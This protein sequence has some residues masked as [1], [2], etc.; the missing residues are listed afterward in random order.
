[1][2]HGGGRLLAVFDTGAAHDRGAG[3]TPRG[4]E[5]RAGQPGNFHSHTRGYF[6]RVDRQEA[7]RLKHT[8]TLTLSRMRLAMRN[9]AFLFFSLIMPIAFLFIYAGIFG[10]GIRQVV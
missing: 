8:W 9:R 2:P 10:R 4:E 3:E 6:P 1:M 5:Q 7:P